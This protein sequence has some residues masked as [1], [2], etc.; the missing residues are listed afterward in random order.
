MPKGGRL[1]LITSLFYHQEILLPTQLFFE[2]VVVSKLLN[3]LDLTK[4]IREFILSNSYVVFF[5][6]EFHCITFIYGH[7]IW[8]MTERINS[9]I[10]RV[11]WK[12]HFLCWVRSFVTRVELKVKVLLLH[13]NR[14]SWGGTGISFGRLMDMY[15]ASR[16][17]ETHAIGS[18]FFGWPGSAQG[19]LWQTIR[20]FQWKKEVCTFL[21]R[22]HLAKRKREKFN[23]FTSCWWVLVRQETELFSI[24]CK[25]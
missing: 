22:N 8:V 12:R 10:Q 15:M 19:F 20:K 23:I 4:C 6:S 21:L 18:M 17:R 5:L 11:E 16:S 2:Q 3:F 7:E 13:I 1:S 9:K 24:C 14:G 25:D